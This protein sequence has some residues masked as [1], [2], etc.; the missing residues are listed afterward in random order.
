[1]KPVIIEVGLNENTSREENPHV[2]ISPREIADDILACAK[3]GAAVIHF[4][5]RDP[6]TGDQRTCDLA[7]YREAML[8]VRQARCDV[9]MYPTYAPFLSGKLDPVQERFGHVLA[10]A[11]DPEIG[12]R[13]GPLDMGSLNLVMAEGG[14]LLPGSD[15][16]PLELS[17][18]QNPL[19][20]LR[21]ML[22]EYDSRSMISALA[23]FEPGHL[24]LTML[25]LADGL[26]RSANL[27]FFLSDRWLH[28]PLPTPDGL[29]D[30]LRLLDRL[31]GDRRIEWVCAPSGIES[32]AAL[33]ELLL[34]AL[35]RDGHVRVGVGDCPLAASGR[36]NA[37][38]VAETVALAEALGRKPASVG[39]T[40]RALS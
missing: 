15:S 26:G 32:Q 17:V 13:I 9:L 24:R 18:Y 7:L 21:R 8:R 22:E 40:L 14:E 16:L 35:R 27:K 4:H 20:L 37:E 11:D 2:P 36:T 1:M 12:L 3:A 39:D 31:R 38:L 34:H 33:E 5:A 6:E 10:L 29:D 25:L 28:G 23:I 30:Y 19:P